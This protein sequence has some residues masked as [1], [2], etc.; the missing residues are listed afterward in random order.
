MAEVPEQ[1]KRLTE[2]VG[3]A[4]SL[5]E[6]DVSSSADRELYGI[7]LRSRASWV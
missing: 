6:G 3:S 2:V 5:K 1:I 4:L 7:F